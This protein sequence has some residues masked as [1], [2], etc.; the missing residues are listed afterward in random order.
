MAEKTN[1]VING[2]PYYRLQKVVGHKVNAAGNEVPVK[3][4][5]YGN[6]KKEAEAKWREYEAKKNAGLEGK[7][8]YFG[9]MAD[10]WIYTF[11]VNDP[12]LKDRTK[13]LYITAWKNYVAPSN[14]YHLPLNEITASTIQQF[15]NSLECS[16]NVIATINKTMSRFYKYLV[17]EGYATHNITATL[18]LKKDKDKSAEDIVIWSE[19]ELHTILHSFDKAQD[20]FRLRFLIILGAFTGCRIS[21]LL[22]LKYSDI[23]ENGLRVSRQVVNTPTFERGKATTHK[24]EIGELKSASSYRTIPL[25]DVVMKELYRHKL[26]QKEDMMKNGYRT[27]YIFTTG[28]GGLYDDRNINT[29]CNRYYKKIGVPQRGFHTYRHTFGT[30]LCNRGVPIQT[31][32]VL[33]GHADI[34]ITARYY[35]NVSLDEKAK[36]VNVLAD[37]MQA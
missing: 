14:I 32:S 15:Y 9:I 6:N 16:G 25:S 1:C 22:G 33:L 29:A 37:I 27:E 30:M 12:K 5:F 24:L 3:K 13:D 18:T 34:K 36:A 7:K 2:K 28:S 21:E 26:W 23:T 35:I 10:N 11:L 19:E 31:A 4:V 17:T 20:G 8:Q